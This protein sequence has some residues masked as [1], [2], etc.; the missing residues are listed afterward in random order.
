MRNNLGFGLLEIVVAI[1]VITASLFAL[2]AT[3]RIAY[4]A[5][6]EASDRVRAGFLLEEGFEAVKTIRDSGWATIQNLTLDQPYYLVFSGAAWQ[7]TTTAQIIDAIFTRS[8]VARSVLRDASY[9]IASSGAN[10]ADARKIEFTISWSERARSLTM[11]GVTY[12]M[13]LFLE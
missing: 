5:T 6:V 11:N 8:F 4:V 1:G 2:S 3:A 7:A 13:N 12:L 10:D 9:N